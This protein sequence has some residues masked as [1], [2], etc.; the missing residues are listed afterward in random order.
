[1]HRTILS[2]L[3]IVLMAAAA[4][5]ATAH[6]EGPFYRKSFSLHGFDSAILAT[7]G[8][9]ATASVSYFEEIASI[10]PEQQSEVQKYAT[11]NCHPLY[12]MRDGKVVEA[13]YNCETFYCLGYLNSV[14]KQCKS[15]DG[16]SFGGV[17]E[18]STRFAR[19]FDYPP[20]KLFTDFPASMQTEAMRRRAADLAR[21][22]CYPF[23]V[24]SFDAV[25]GE[26]Y[27]CDQIGSYP[28]FS[29]ARTCTYNAS[30]KAYECDVPERQ[31]EFDIRYAVL[32]NTGPFSQSSAAAASSSAQSSGP[33]T[34][35]DVKQGEYGYTAIMSLAERGV[36]GGY[37]DGT[38]RPQRTLNRAEFVKMLIAGMIPSAVSKEKNC[39]PD[40]RD[41]WYS[42]YVCGIK[43]LGW[44]EGY[45]D[46]TFGP[47]RTILREEALKLVMVSVTPN[48]SSDAPLPP[49]VSV[50]AWYAPYVRKAVELKII[51]EA[52]FRPGVN[53]TRADAAVWMYRADK[54]KSSR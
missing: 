18:I 10:T 25:I 5:P 42:P 52:V 4:V 38:F 14:P 40:V 19:P 34:F 46:G 44:V 49:D 15:S 33:R 31:G 35:T 36:I 7:L 24:M 50:S 43:K 37:P 23:Y 11:I 28:N 47:E 16:K 27:R 45:R 26:G 13:G 39:F 48:F 29:S 3:V 20:H 8:Y 9:G 53:A 41:Q 54:Y 6:A 30:E 22:Q 1:M 12:I 32:G 2:T 17:V 51:L 21:I